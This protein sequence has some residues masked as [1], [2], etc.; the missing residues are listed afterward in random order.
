M[1]SELPFTPLAEGF[2]MPA[3]FEPHRGCWLLWPT[4]LDNWWTRYFNA[5][6]Q[7]IGK[8][9]AAATKLDQAHHL[10]AMKSLMRVVKAVQ[11]IEVIAQ[12]SLSQPPKV[13]SADLT[14][15]INDYES[16]YS[17]LW[18]K[19]R[20]R[21]RLAK[22]LFSLGKSLVGTFDYPSALSKISLVMQNIAKEDK[23]HTN[24][25][26]KGYSR[27]YDISVQLLSLTVSEALQHDQEHMADHVDQLKS[28]IEKQKQLYGTLDLE[29]PA[30]QHLQEVMESLNRVGN[31]P[32]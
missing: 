12:P 5:L 25:N 3:E 27:L 30:F 24:R 6:A 17:A 7:W 26:K 2:R 10:C 21:K 32:N 4:R 8:P 1:I 19:S 22:D 20:D 14:K 18:W 31:D 29:T 11:E 16:S 28:I 23:K 9:M 15:T 13:L